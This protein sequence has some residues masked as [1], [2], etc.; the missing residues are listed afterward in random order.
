MKT[1]TYLT[2][3]ASMWAAFLI[4]LEMVV[5]AFCLAANL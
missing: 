5:R 4:C 1:T 2:W 3:N